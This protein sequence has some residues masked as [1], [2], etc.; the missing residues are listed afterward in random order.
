MIKVL[1]ADDDTLARKAI[2]DLLQPERDIGE[3]IETANGGEVLDLCLTHAPDIL[4]LDIDLS[5]QTGIQIAEQLP[6]GPV[7]IF[8]T[9]N[10]QCAITAFDLNVIDYIL[11][12]FNNDRFYTALDKAR[13]QLTFK[14]GIDLQSLSLLIEGNRTKQNTQ[15]KSRLVVRAQG[16][17]HLVD[18]AEINYISGAGNYADVYLLNGNH[19]LHR[20][21]LTA[22]DAELDPDVF[23]RIHRSSIVR[24]SS[25]CELRSKDNGDHSVILKTGEQLTLPR[26]NKDKFDELLQE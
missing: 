3:I 21:T 5:G 14:K 6:H 23:I 8:A 9:G 17:I 18:V 26:R 13:N 1:I 24:R 22:L 20:E 4:F 12:P 25:I 11:K 15:F 2:S 7:I 16:R 19:I 10:A